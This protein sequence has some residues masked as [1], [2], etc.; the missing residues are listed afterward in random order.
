MFQLSRVP[1]LKAEYSTPHGKGEKMKT[2]VPLTLRWQ[3]EMIYVQF[4]VIFSKN[5]NCS[6][7]INLCWSQTY[8]STFKPYLG[9]GQSV[10]VSLKIKC[11]FLCWT[12]GTYA[13]VLQVHLSCR[14]AV[15]RASEIRAWEKPPAPASHL[16]GRPDP[17]N[18]A[19]FRKMCSPAGFSSTRLGN[20]EWSPPGTD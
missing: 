8:L 4:M 16:C 15:L 20:S 14:L 12:A 6:P 17:A 10:F 1:P 7:N 18:K 13:P 5:S 2:G 3:A 11:E 9:F 19:S